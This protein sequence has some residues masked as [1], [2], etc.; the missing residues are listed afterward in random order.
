M[1]SATTTIEFDQTT[2]AILQVLKEKAAAQG[3]SLAELLRPL[4][5]AT[6]GVY[7]EEAKTPFEL[8][9]DLIG[10]IDSSVPDPTSP[11][12]HTAFGQHLLE[13]HR[14]QSETFQA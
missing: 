6:N 1:N 14:K 3:F 8:S 11:P 4:A 2:A 10:S 12:K 5:E 9:S 7:S 13:K